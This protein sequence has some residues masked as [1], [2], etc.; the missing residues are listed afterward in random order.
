M[1]GFGIFILIVAGVLPLFLFGYL[2]GVKRYL[3]LVA[4]YKPGR[5]NDEEKFARNIGTACFSGGGILLAL[6]VYLIF[7]GSIS[8]FAIIFVS[9][10]GGLVPALLAFRTLH[11]DRSKNT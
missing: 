6:A 7:V 1:D 5:I 2:I 11:S 9:I 10:L 8:N 4:G 3:Y